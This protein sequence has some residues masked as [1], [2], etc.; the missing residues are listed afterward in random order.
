MQ[1]HWKDLTLDLVEEG[2][3]ESD[4]N[5]LL[6]KLQ[7]HLLAHAQRYGSKAS[8]A[9]PFRASTRTTPG[10]TSSA[11]GLALPSAL[12]LCSEAT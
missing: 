10:A 7:S 11:W 3:L 2:R 5:D 1:T 4:F 9:K 6:R 12:P 8:G